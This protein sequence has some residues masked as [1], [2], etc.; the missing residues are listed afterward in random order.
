MTH[1]VSTLFSFRCRRALLGLVALTVPALVSAQGSCAGT[2]RA[3]TPQCDTTPAKLPFAPTGWKTVALDHFSM[4]ATDPRREAA[5]Y[6][7]LMGWKMRSDD[8]TKIVMDMGDVGAMEIRG[9]Y[10][11]P[12]PPVLSPADSAARA[13]RSSGAGGRGGART[14]VRVAWDSFCWVI[15]P[16][17]AKTV[18][19]EL[20]KRGLDPVADN[21]G[22]FES[23]HVKD[24]D[25]F[26]VQISNDAH[27]KARMA[28]AANAPL[29]AP[30]PFESTGWKT[31]WLDHI[32]FGV[33]NYK[34]SAAFYMALLGWKSTGDEGSQNELEIGDVGNI[35]VR[36]GNPNARAPGAPEPPRRA[37]M[38]HVSFGFSPWDTDKVKA[39]L[40][41]R[42]LTGR[43]DTGAKGD[44]HDAAALYK[45]Y[46]TTTPDG[47]DL[48]ISNANKANRTVR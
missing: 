36:G 32:S 6:T 37:S 4:H 33:S 45:S 38:G 2:A 44:I 15:S 22:R 24:P 31:E 7:A 18:E 26:D 9:G 13:A 21:D 29:P 42:G 48:Q 30:A 11:P 46:H 3:A 27:V 28:S 25:G 5:Y 41:K 43:A 34:E 17:N 12:P 16:W 23:F 1:V 47:F 8:G 35:I 14:P 10:Q 20:K 19:A 39:E 40:D